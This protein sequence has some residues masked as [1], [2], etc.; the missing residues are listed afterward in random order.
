MPDDNIKR[1]PP[2][3]M[4]VLVGG[5]AGGFCGFWAGGGTTLA[6]C[7]ASVALEG[8]NPP[9]ILVPIYAIFGSFLYAVAG[10]IVGVIWPLLRGQPWRSTIARFIVLLALVGLSL[11]PFIADPWHG[12]SFSQVRSLSCPW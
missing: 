5:F 9:I 10:A 8:G 1:R 6:F 3:W 2:W 7:V 11:P 12:A 4:L